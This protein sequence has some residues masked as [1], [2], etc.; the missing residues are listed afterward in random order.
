MELG[1]LG[2]QLYLREETLRRKVT[3]VADDDILCWET[4][5]MLKIS[6]I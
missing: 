1:L 3:Y 5:V 4:A 2:R 6:N